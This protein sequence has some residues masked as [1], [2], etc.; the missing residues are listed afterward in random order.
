MN[1]SASSGQSTVESTAHGMG[2]F[3]NR[4]RDSP[5]K[6]VN[7]VVKYGFVNKFSFA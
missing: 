6:K 3:E 4:R 1:N 7:F 2:Q 5:N